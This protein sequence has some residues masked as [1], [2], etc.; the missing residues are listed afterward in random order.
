MTRQS[1]EGAISVPTEPGQKTLDVETAATM[2]QIVG[3]N[4][5]F[6]EEFSTFMQVRGLSPPKS[7]KIARCDSAVS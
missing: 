2:L 6:Q 3:K 4:N 7:Q 5:P 1:N